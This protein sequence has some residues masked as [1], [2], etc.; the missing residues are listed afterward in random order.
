MSQIGDKLSDFE[1]IK[2]LG[3]GAFGVVFL[4]RSH[5]DNQLYVLKKLKHGRRHKEALREA[6]LLRNIKH[7]HI[8]TYHHCF[9]EADCLYLVMEYAEGGDLHRVSIS[10]T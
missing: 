2:E 10:L 5:L 1:I 8:I 9:V 3:R 4:V 7:P 6:R